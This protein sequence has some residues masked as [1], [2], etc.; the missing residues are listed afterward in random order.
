[1]INKTAMKIISFLNLRVYVLMLFD[2][3]K[4]IRN[5]G[6]SYVLDAFHRATLGTCT[7][8]RTFVIIN[9]CAVVND[10][11][12]LLRANLFALFTANAGS[13]TEFA[14]ISPLILAA[15]INDG[16][17]IVRYHG[18]DLCRTLLDTHTA[19]DAT[20]RIDSRDSVRNA[21]GIGN[22]DLG[23]FSASK[24]AVAAEF[25]SVE[26]DVSCLTGRHSVIDRLF[27]RH[28]TGSVTM[29]KRD[30]GTGAGNLN[31][32]NVAELLGRCFSTGDTEIGLRLPVGKRTGVIVTAL[33]AA[34]A[35]VY[36]GQNGSDLFGFFIILNA[37]AAD[38]KREKHTEDDAN[39]YYNSKS[40]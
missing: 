1:M 29:D 8:T 36:A 37:K 40:G 19:A 32:E 22:A 24:T 3:T 38:N 28:V 10:R 14:C 20:A 4:S 34:G 31:S 39:R 21:N 7:A 23:T 16:F 30:H 25:R 12:R 11:N 5:L 13:L 35:T 6:E 9:D 18:N 15:A 27:C 33:K 2:K 17:G 26:A